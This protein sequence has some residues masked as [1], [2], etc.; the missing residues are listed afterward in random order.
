ERVGQADLAEERNFRF[1]PHHHGD[2]YGQQQKDAGK[3]AGGAVFGA[4]FRHLIFISNILRCVP[5]THDYTPRDKK[6]KNVKGI[7]PCADLVTER[8]ENPVM[9]LLPIH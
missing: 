1:E 5:N 8:E 2:G 4:E 9:G 3:A 6:Q 7:Y